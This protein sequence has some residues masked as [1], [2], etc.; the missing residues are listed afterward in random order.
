MNKDGSKKM[1]LLVDDDEIHLEITKNMLEQHYEII[2]ARSGSEALEFFTKAIFPDLVL[3]DVLMPEMDGWET[4]NRIKGIG[5]LKD[6]PI[7][8]L[9]SME[10][11]SAEIHAHRLGA[12]DYIKKPCDPE[13][14]LKRVA[15]VLSMA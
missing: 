5:L 1:I 14:L 15:R 7:I 6:I 9:T 12:A 13:D 10:D 4:Y 8:F 11:A 2:T 3:L